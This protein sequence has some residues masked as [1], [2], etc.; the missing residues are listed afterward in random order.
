MAANLLQFHFCYVCAMN[1]FLSFVAYL[2][3]FFHCR[4]ERYCLEKN[5]SERGPG[6]QSKIRS[7]KTYDDQIL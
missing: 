4:P 3:A 1:I 2:C 5:Y 6:R 7:H